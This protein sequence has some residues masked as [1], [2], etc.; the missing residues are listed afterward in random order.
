[1]R[2]PST[3]LQH[4]TDSELQMTP[5]IDVVFQLMIFF[6][7]T[8][9]VHVAEYVLP[10][11]VTNPTQ[12]AAGAT[13]SPDAASDFRELVIRVMWQGGQPQWQLNGQNTPSLTAMRQQLKEVHA[14]APQAPLVIHPDPETP[15]EYVV[16]AYDLSRLMG[17]QKVQ[18]AVSEHD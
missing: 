3:Y 4:G 12:A 9:G 2:R 8:S 6:V 15:L 18:L 17:F 5:M 14:I 1:V 11:R 10:S 13:P 7:W 16:Q